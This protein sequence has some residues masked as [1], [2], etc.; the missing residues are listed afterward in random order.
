MVASVVL[1]GLKIRIQP[2]LRTVG[3]AISLSCSASRWL[4]KSLKTMMSGD[5]W[6]YSTLNDWYGISWLRCS[7]HDPPLSTRLF[8]IGISF[9]NY[10]VHALVDDCVF[11][12]TT[13]VF[14]IFCFASFELF[15][16]CTIITRDD[17]MSCFLSW[18]NLEI[19][20]N[21]RRVWAR[22]EGKEAC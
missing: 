9:C 13:A 8:A 20:H 10:T 17:V 15:A 6:T 22:R 16:G 12:A 2:F 7:S 1:Y 11:A 14:D 21:V 18:S 5:R 4:T 19:F 3:T